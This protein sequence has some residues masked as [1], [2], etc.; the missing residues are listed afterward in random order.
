MM[1]AVITRNHLKFPPNYPA[2]YSNNDVKSFCFRGTLRLFKTLSLCETFLT[3]PSSTLLLPNT[4]KK[5]NLEEHLEE[6]LGKGTY[7]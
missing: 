3:S 1:R 2:L 6:T 5:L 4:N 7:F